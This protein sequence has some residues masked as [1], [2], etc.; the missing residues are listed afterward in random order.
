MCR[1]ALH[2]LAVKKN[3]E[4][5]LDITFWTISSVNV[6][7]WS[8]SSSGLVK[9]L[10]V[11]LRNF[12]PSFICVTKSFR[13]AVTKLRF[14]SFKNHRI[15]VFKVIMSMSNE[16]KEV[17][18]TLV[19]YLYKWHTFI[20]QILFGKDIFFNVYRNWLGYFKKFVKSRRWL[21]YS[22]EIGTLNCNSIN[23]KKTREMK[24]CQ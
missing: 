1:T 3:W 20:S 2:A 17:F 11:L 6:F 7:P 10:A 19:E 4:L 9:C 15:W 13:P 14:W 8:A 22:A 12:I 16:H 18:S 24:V 23:F 5:S 21:G